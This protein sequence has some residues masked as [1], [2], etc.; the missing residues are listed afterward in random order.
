MDIGV[1]QWWRRNLKD[2]LPRAPAGQSPAFSCVIG[3]QDTANLDRGV[4]TIA[5]EGETA[6]ATGLRRIGKEPSVLV[7]QRSHLW[8]AHPG[9]GAVSRDED[10]GRFRPGKLQIRDIGVVGHPAY[11]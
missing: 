4:D 2:R 10:T 8:A 7:A 6:D 1:N 9:S 5:V 11:V 3:A